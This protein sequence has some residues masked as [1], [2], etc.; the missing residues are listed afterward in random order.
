MLNWGNNYN[1]QQFHP[2]S[3]TPKTSNLPLTYIQDIAIMSKLITLYVYLNDRLIEA[4]PTLNWAVAETKRK[5]LIATGRYNTCKFK[6]KTRF[7]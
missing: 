3:Q 2:I 6:I 1:L 4:Y 7:F 5:E